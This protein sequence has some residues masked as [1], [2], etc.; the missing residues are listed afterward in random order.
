MGSLR[1][2]ILSRCS[3]EHKI[4]SSLQVLILNSCIIFKV[5]K[6][7]FD[8]PLTT[9]HTKSIFENLISELTEI[10]REYKDLSEELLH[11]SDLLIQKIKKYIR[12]RVD[13]ITD[14]WKKGEFKH[15][16]NIREDFIKMEEIIPETDYYKID[17]N[18]PDRKL[19]LK[20]NLQKEKE[21][22]KENLAKSF[23]KKGSVL[24]WVKSSKRKKKKFPKIPFERDLILKNKMTKL[25]PEKVKRDRFQFFDQN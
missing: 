12:E 19:D 7:F 21:D 6:L 25:N 11:H 2:F 5:S 3:I 20:D 16:P 17:F 13:D 8:S 1:L 15:Y 9:L 14:R 22:N 24:N 18:N 10:E 23:M 4:G